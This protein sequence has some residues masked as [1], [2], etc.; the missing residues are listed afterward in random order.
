LKKFEFGNTVQDDLWE[1][2]TKAGHEDKTLDSDITVKQIMDTWTLQ[3]GY[4]VVQ[5]DRN[6]NKLTTTQK[7][8]LLN[9]LNSIQNTQ[10]YNKYQWFVPITYTTRQELSF[11]FE[12][13]PQWLKENSKRKKIR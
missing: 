1:E 11:D 5:A 9:P 4:P 10:E 7:W 13:R 3:K 6:G 8:F 2:L 12:K